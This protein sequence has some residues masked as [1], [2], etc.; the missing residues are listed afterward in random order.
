M[1]G[2]VASRLVERFGRPVVLIAG[3]ASG[4]D[5]K[6]SG[7]AGGPVRPARR[8]H[9]LRRA[10]RALRR[11]P[12]RGRPLDPSRARR[13]R[14]PRRSPRTP[15]PQLTD[16]DLRPRVAV[17]AIVRGPELG[18]RSVPGARPARAVR[19]RQPRRHAARRRLRARPAR[20]RRRGQAPPLPR[21]PARP[22]RRLGDR[23]RLR[24]PD[25]P[26]PP[27]EPLRR[28]VPAQREPLERHGRA[29]ARRPA[30]L[31]HRRAVRGAPRL[32]RRAVAARGG[33]VDARGA[34][35]LRRAGARV[36]RRGGACSSRSVSGAAARGAAARGRRPES[37]L[38]R[39]TRPIES[40][41]ARG[42]AESSSFATAAN[43]HGRPASR[44]AGDFPVTSRAGGSPL[45]PGKMCVMA[46]VER[47]QD[48]VDELLAELES[49]KPDVR[50][51][52][53]R[54]APS[55]SRR[56]RTTGSVRRSG[57]EF[58]HHPWG[59][60]KILAGLR[61]DEPTIAA[62]LLHDTV[63]DTGRRDRRHPR[64]VR[65]TRSR[66]SSRASPS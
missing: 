47:H 42:Q 30:D 35:G 27:P 43:H 4:G 64:R 21:P 38:V 1:I 26:L 8:A 54:R 52:P 58:I 24:R 25:R 49:Y 63:E 61:M 39:S 48:L 46:V 55:S 2:I 19:A 37:S 62:A 66:R 22:R 57:Q 50:P 12:R 40:R 34:G 13:R 18:L 20:H 7:R 59:A 65:R 10:P 36:R 31:R 14:S 23:V 29:A 3:S 6:G 41:Q 51:R 16:E 11:P 28:R 45:R 53:D 33:R 15:T 9:R 32:V 44:S 17:D 56:R 5:W 60:A